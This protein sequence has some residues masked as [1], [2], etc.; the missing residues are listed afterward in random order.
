MEVV[1][2]HCDVCGAEVFQNVESEQYTPLKECPSQRCRDNKQQGKLNCNIRTSK[3]VRYQEMRVQ[4]MSE[5]VP[6]GGV[7][8][9]LNVVLG[10]DLTRSVLPGDAITLTGVYVPVQM[11]WFQA[12][13]K[14]TMQDM[15]IDAHY[16]RKHKLGYNETATDSAE[17]AAKV[18]E[19]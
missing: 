14:G 11:P 5:H 7:P 18:E 19:A 8:R 10:G 1:T 3:F 17:V 16:V 6:T 9:S 4:E 15:Y 13:K 12:R 2:Y